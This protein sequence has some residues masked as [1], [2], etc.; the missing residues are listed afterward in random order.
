MKGRN[1]YLILSILYLL[2]F[3][4]YET[5]AYFSSLDQEVSD[6]MRN[7]LRLDPPDILIDQIRKTNITEEDSKE[8]INNL[9]N[10]VE[11]Y[12]YLDILKN[13]PQPKENYHN[14]VDLIEELEN[15][16]TEERPLY[17]FVRDVNLIISK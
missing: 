5:K 7:N 15:V 1:T 2:C 6:F 16:N 17:D 4:S 11:R 10:I 9:K 13:P 14:I 8:L 3:D 12:V